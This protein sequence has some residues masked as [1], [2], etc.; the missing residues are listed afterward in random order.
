MQNLRRKI[1]ILGLCLLFGGLVALG[2]RSGSSPSPQLAAT[3]ARQPAIQTGIPVGV[4]QPENVVRIK[5]CM[6]PVGNETAA[7]HLTAAANASNASPP[8]PNY[9]PPQVKEW[10]DPTNFGNRFR[11]DAKGQP[12]NNRLLVVLHET[13][14]DATGAVNTFQTEHLNDSQQVSYHAVITR[15][16]KI[17]YLVP[18]HLRAFGAGNSEFV[19]VDGPEAVRTNPNI[20]SSVNNFAYHISLE[21]PVD[22]L[23]NDN[24]THSGYTEAQYRSTAWLIARTETP[25]SRITTHAAIDRLQA[26][27]DPRSFD[28]PKLLNYLDDYPRPEDISIC[29]GRS[30]G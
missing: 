29:P 21:T 8:L 4:G 13:V 15:E 18:P 1:W 20:S 27:Q 19:G 17:I 26:R 5:D 9:R 2:F 11:R 24:P 7:F 28:Y 22:G 23:L 14:G 3:P 16:G 6:P 10:V 30:Q 12:V 25:N